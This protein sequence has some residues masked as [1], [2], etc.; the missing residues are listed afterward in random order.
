MAD[1]VMY[2]TKT[3][4]LK[5]PFA[6]EQIEALAAQKGAE[7][8]APVE[9]GKPSVWSKIHGIFSR[10]HG[11]AKSLYQR[12]LARVEVEGKE[13][14]DKELNQLADAMQSAKITEADLEKDR[15]IIARW[16]RAKAAAE[17]LPAEIKKR[18]DAEKKIDEINRAV[19]KL[20]DEAKPWADTFN[21]A[22]HNV[23]S[24]EADASQIQV[25]DQRVTEM[26][27]GAM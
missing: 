17:R 18:E 9:N 19:A 1:E 10:R 24:L 6:R 27:G 2:G 26:L 12:L 20:F 11:D 7:P 8:P 15:E 25:L 21:Q 22:S 4:S 14:S 23:R 3:V 13:L 5:D 16:K